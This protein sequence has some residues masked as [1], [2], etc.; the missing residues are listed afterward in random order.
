MR[1]S[2]RGAERLTNHTPSRS[3]VDWVA[4]QGLAVTSGI[5]VGLGGAIGIILT[6]ATSGWIQWWW[7][8]GLMAYVA[9]LQ[10]LRQAE[11]KSADL[12]TRLTPSLE[13]VFEPRSPFIE[14]NEAFS[15]ES[16]R[17]MFDRIADGN[18]SPDARPD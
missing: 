4:R 9:L 3:P 2:D 12:E 6:V 18:W 11:A 10:K 1:D 5:Y 8:V 16:A 17:T 7:A 13:F 15:E 14:D